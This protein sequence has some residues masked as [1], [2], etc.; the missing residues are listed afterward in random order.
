MVNLTGSAFP[1]RANT[2]GADIRFEQSGVELLYWLEK[3]DYANRSALVWVN[4][5][6]VSV[7]ESVVRMWYGNPNASSSSN[8]NATFKRVIDDGQPLVGS[9]TFN[10]GTGTTAY[11]NSGN[12]NNG[13][14]YYDPAWVD[15]KF[16]KA[17]SFDG[18]YD[19]VS[20][21]LK[22]Q[23]GARSMFLWIRYN[24]LTGP[25]G[26]SLTGT[27]EHTNAY[28]Y[29]GI[30]DGGQ[31]YSFAANVGGNY[32]YYFTTENWYF[33]GF[34][35]DGINTIKYFVNGIQVDFKT[36]TSDATATRNFSI[37]RVDQGHN[38]NG[39]IDEVAIYNR[40]L[41]AS[42][43]SDLYNN[44]GY[45]T[46]NYPGRVLVR[47][48]TSPEPSIS[49]GIGKRIITVNASGG[50]DFTKIQDAINNV[51]ARDTTILVQSGT[52]YETVVVNKPSLTLK[53]MDTG[54]GKPVVTA[55]GSSNVITL[56][57]GTTTLDGFR[58]INANSRIGIYVSSNQNVIRNN[59]V[60]NNDYG[61]QLISSSYNTLS[62][63]TI[64]NNVGRGVQMTSSNNNMLFNNSLSNSNIGIFLESS[65]GN[66]LSSNNIS[67][68]NPHGIYLYSS[69]SNS[70][71][72][73]LFKNTI[74]AFFG[75]TI[76]NNQWNITKTEGINLMGGPYLGGNFWDNPSETG[77]SR[78]CEDNDR[79]GICD[80]SLA[81][82]GSSN[83]DY[84]PLTFKPEGEA[85]ELHT[86]AN[87]SYAG[88]N[89]T[90]SFTAHDVKDVVLTCDLNLNNVNKNII[91]AVSD[92]ITEITINGLAS[93][94]YNWNVTCVNST[95]VA[96]SSPT[97]MFKIDVLPPDI[98]LL[99]P[100]QDGLINSNIV[101]FK[102][103]GTDNLGLPMKGELWIDNEK[104]TTN[105]ILENNTVKQ[106]SLILPDGVHTW[107]ASIEDDAGN[108]N[109][110][111]VRRFDIDSIKPYVI[112]DSPENNANSTLPFMSFNFTGIDNRNTSLTYDFY[113]DGMRANSS[114]ILNTTPAN[115]TLPVDS[116]SH[117]WYVVL[118]DIA[119]NSNTSS[120]R[121]FNSLTDLWIS[122]ISF[123]NDKPLQD[124]V[125]T[126]YVAIENN[127]ID[128]KNVNIFVED[129]N[130][131]SIGTKK[132][133]INANSNYSFSLPW[134]LLDLEPGSHSAVVEIAQYP[135]LDLNPSNNTAFAN[136][137]IIEDIWPPFFS[138]IYFDPANITEHSTGINFTIYIRDL[139]VGVNSSSA[140][141]HYAFN[142]S[143][144]F[145][146]MALSGQDKYTA[147][148]IAEWDANQGNNV[149]FYASA[150]DRKGN[151]NE[152]V[153]Q[154]EYIDTINDIPVITILSPRNFSVFGGTRIVEWLCDNDNEGPCTSSVYYWKPHSWAPSY[155]DPGYW[156][157]GI[158]TKLADVDE[159]TSYLWDTSGINGKTKL[160]ITATDGTYNV[161][162]ISGEFTIDNN[163]VTLTIENYYHPPSDAYVTNTTGF[164][165]GW[166]AA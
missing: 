59:T 50:T 97:W 132:I 164:I 98:S 11:D 40:A 55:N 24:S 39:T 32:N 74:N 79:D 89:V 15:G 154:Q 103:L 128:A 34:T 67:N 127:G 155:P 69:S 22:I 87:G 111:E 139:E 129:E 60:S 115:L 25:G 137:S 122:N 28:T 62:N 57:V 94:K 107:N 1:T 131:K 72:N 44:N 2:S 29:T 100:V 27:Q 130:G 110:S 31:G 152:S 18:S 48:Y 96:V 125:I 17:L 64:I 163:N 80:Q 113:L 26:F 159:N 54:G 91:S 144:N 114:T 49:I 102:M 30:S 47:K 78:T 58:V 63:N 99:S 101:Q 116:R 33:V 38:I 83:I 9:W 118:L 165:H 41:S 21:P 117:S 93:G 106:L 136:V 135:Y 156:E 109:T 19:Y 143:W 140:K 61:L 150:S 104:N 13:V 88:S 124:G 120:T 151:N 138:E 77:F 43:I 71:Y 12:G 56:N 75:S 126:I 65:K 16:G 81:L 157:Q 92:N 160:N 90:F 7:G 148:L 119:N 133:S 82:Y 14:F 45:T 161:S 158:W 112:M 142:R 5:T 105:I 68:N 53:G 8:V 4:V 153:R 23:T 66:I 73:N 6:S 123:S 52:Y 146:P 51:T 20:T 145:I 42:E 37:G 84:L 95:L 85:I 147:S 166:V 35:M 162:G 134:N 46:T 3:W 149:T 70:I 36:Y 108:K 10:E 86:P 121:T 76:Y 141:L